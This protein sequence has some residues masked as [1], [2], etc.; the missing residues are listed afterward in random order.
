MAKINRLDQSEKLQAFLNTKMGRPIDGVRGERKEHKIIFRLDNTQY[1]ALIK[2]GEE[3]NIDN[4]NL[5]ARAL[6]CGAL[7]IT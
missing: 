1:Q 4:P 3:L 7:Q 2:A 5:A 6:L